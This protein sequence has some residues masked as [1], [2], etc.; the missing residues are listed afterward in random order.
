MTLEPGISRLSVRFSVRGGGDVCACNRNDSKRP[1]KTTPV[2]RYLPLEIAGT[3]V[4]KKESDGGYKTVSWNKLPW[5]GWGSGLSYR[6]SSNLD[7]TEKLR[8]SI[9][10]GSRVP[11]P[12]VGEEGDFVLFK[13]PESEPF[14]EVFTFEAPASGLEAEFVL[15]GTSLHAYVDSARTRP[16]RG[17]AW[18]RI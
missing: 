7:D 15:A 5:G 18:T 1:W 8:A 12:V 4:L 17:R 14:Q 10:W 16:A 11:Y 13:L 6:L 3:K 2:V 9:A